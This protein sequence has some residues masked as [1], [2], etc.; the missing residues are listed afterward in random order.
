MSDSKEIQQTYKKRYSLEQLK[1]F[2]GNKAFLDAEFNCKE[3]NKDVKQ[4]LSLLEIGLI[5]TDA[6]YN[7]LEIYDRMVKPIGEKAVVNGFVKRLTG[8][9]QEDIDKAT[10]TY[11]DVVR[12]VNAICSKWN[13]A[14]IFCFAIILSKFCRTYRKHLRLF[15]WNY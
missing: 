12:D 15:H 6:D 10:T 2:T 13:A 8:I 9:K 7:V 3:F 4:N 11:A 1:S 5:I 14:K